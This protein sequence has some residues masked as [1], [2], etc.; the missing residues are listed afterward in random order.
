M[1]CYSKETGEIRFYTVG[2][3][4]FVIFPNSINEKQV[5]KLYFGLNKEHLQVER[6]Q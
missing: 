2:N 4:S 6:L 5:E 1:E 3:K